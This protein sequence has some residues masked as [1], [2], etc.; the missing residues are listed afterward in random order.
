L[1]EVFLS[2]KRILN[3]SVSSFPGAVPVLPH[4]IG[5]D[6]TEPFCFQ[7]LINDERLQG[8]GFGISPELLSFLPAAGPAQTIIERVGRQGNEL[9]ACPGKN[10]SAR[11]GQKGLTGE[12]PG[13]II[14]S[15]TDRSVLACPNQNSEEGVLE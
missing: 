7:I 14:Q 4:V 9:P 1:N 2:A 11:F 10:K 8:Y 15:P 5:G 12:G 13:Y 3:W 6:R